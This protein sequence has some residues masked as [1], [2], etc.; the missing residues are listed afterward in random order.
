MGH[1]KRYNKK[2]RGFPKRNTNTSGGGGGTTPTNVNQSGPQ[3]TGQSIAS[4]MT[5]AAQATPAVM[6]YFQSR[7]AN[8]LMEEERKRALALDKDVQALL[9]N[10]QTLRNPY[11]NLGVATQAAEMEAQQ[12]DASLAN[13]LDTMRAGGFGGSGATALARKAA[14]SKQG[15]SADIQKQE[16]A[17]QTKFAEGE[18]QLQDAIE[19]RQIQDINRKQ[20]E[21]DNARLNEQALRDEAA[22]ATQQGI[23]STVTG[24]TDVLTKNPEILSGL[25][26]A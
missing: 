8:D 11:A 17:N 10:R 22:M 19:E 5:V 1:L 4:I 24:L 18:K 21:L 20:T 26:G 9:A 15:I 6:G 23:T 25:F 12:V 13:T 16:Q 3:D 2:Y 14:E 7:K